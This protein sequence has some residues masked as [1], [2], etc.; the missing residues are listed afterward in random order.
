MLENSRNISKGRTILLLVAL[1]LSSM[2]TLGDMVVT[3]IAA[4]LYEVFADSPEALINFGIT[5][6]ALVGLPFSFLAGWLC[7]RFDKKWIMVIGF[8]AF[9]ITA[10]LGAAVQDIWYFVITR[11][12]ATGVAWGTTNAAAMSIIA[13]LFLDEDTHG[14]MVGYYNATMSILGAILA[15]VAGILAA[16]GNWTTAFQAY[17]IAIPVA[18]MLIVFLPSM[19]PR[20]KADTEQT[21]AKASESSPAGWWKPLMPLTV[22]VFFIA[23]MYFV[24]MY[25]IA[26]FVAD[27]GIGDEAFVGTVASVMTLSSAVGSVAFGFFFAKMKNTVYFA[28]VVIMGVAFIVMA[29]AP[30]EIMTVVCG[31]VLGFFWPFYFCYFYAHCT[32]LVP[33]NRAGTATGIVALSDG[34]AATLCS[35][36]LTGL[37]GATGMNSVQLWPYFGIVLIAVAVISIVAHFAKAK[38][39]AEAVS[40]S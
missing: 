1:F 2:C 22:Q 31:A 7:D 5:G 17:W 14:K 29:M 19:K 21:G 27:A 26:L 4:N 9:T 6:P 23:L 12:I 18:I 33:G 16:S 40:I 24:A 38:K 28:P 3:P 11:S 20:A 30:S 32:E 25:M 8:V 35:Y 10:V 13:D 36:L 37:I 39:G 15:Q 34:L